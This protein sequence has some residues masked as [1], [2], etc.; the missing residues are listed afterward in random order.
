MS[1]RNI[2]LNLVI[3]EI[4]NFYLSISIKQM[5]GAIQINRAAVTMAICQFIVILLFGLFVQFKSTTNPQGDMAVE[6]PNAVNLL[7]TTYPSFQDVHIMIFVG[8]GFLMCFIKS[9]NWGSIGYN[10]LVACWSIQITILW[11]AFWKN[12][13]SYYDNPSTYSF[14]KLEITVH[15]IIE[16]EFGAAAVLISMGAIVGKCSLF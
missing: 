13:L 7:K 1:Q 15:T 6:N 10:Y 9:H 14:A 4:N 5:S 12:V 3:S 11:E 2:I 8:F 16:A